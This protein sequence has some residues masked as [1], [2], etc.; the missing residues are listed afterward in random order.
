LLKGE[1]LE[2]VNIKNKASSKK[3]N[4]IMSVYSN[5]TVWEFKKE[6]AK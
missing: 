4:M 6:L 1:F 5:A 2:K 3:A